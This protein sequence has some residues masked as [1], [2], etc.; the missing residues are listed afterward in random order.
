MNVF[1]LI[2][3]GLDFKKYGTFHV[4]GLQAGNSPSKAEPSWKYSSIGLFLKGPSFLL[5]CNS[6]RQAGALFAS[7]KLTRQVVEPVVR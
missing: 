6:T 4:C 2:L 5:F 3:I 1:G 7:G